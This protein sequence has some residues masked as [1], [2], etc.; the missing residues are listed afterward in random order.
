MA[1]EPVWE[2]GFESP[3]PGLMYVSTNEL[4]IETMLAARPDAPLFRRPAEPWE[5]IGGESR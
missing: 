4:L 5:P 2:Y 1:S 3:Q